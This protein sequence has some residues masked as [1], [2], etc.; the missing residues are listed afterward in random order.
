VLWFLLMV[1]IVFYGVRLAFS[2]LSRLALL[3]GASRAT[4]APPS[5]PARR[6]ESAKHTVSDAEFEEL[7]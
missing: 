6:F 2:L 1:V 4:P 7:P 5:P 3:A